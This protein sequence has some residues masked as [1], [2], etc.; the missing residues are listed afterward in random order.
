[1]S[2]SGT[3]KKNTANAYQY[4]PRAWPVTG[5]AATSGGSPGPRTKTTPRSQRNATDASASSSSSP[6]TTHF[7]FRTS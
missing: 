3:T 6:T 1:M 7:P 2:S 4:W 5:A